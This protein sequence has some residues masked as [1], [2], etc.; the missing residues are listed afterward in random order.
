MGI[1]GRWSRAARAI[2]ERLPILSQMQNGT[3]EGLLLGILLGGI[4]FLCLGGILGGLNRG[5][6]GA[7]I[8][9]ISGMLLG[10]MLGGVIGAMAGARRIPQVGTIQLSIEMDQPMGRYA[11]GDVVSG[12]VS[13]TP[14]NTLRVNGGQ[15]YFMCR[16]FYAHDQ[17]NEN[18]MDAPE[19]VRHSREYLVR[20]AEFLPAS[21]LRRGGIVRCPFSF[22]IPEGTPPTHHGYIC[23]VRWSLHAMVEAPDLQPSKAQREVFVQAIPPVIPTPSGG[24][25]SS[26]PTQSCQLILVLPRAVYAEGEVVN[27][28]VNITALEDLAIDEVRAMLLR[29]ENTPSGDNHIVYMDSRDPVSGLYRGEREFGGQGTTYVWLEAETSLSSALH[30]KPTQS[31]SFPFA[32]AIPTHWRP[33]F[34]TKDGKVTWK[35]GVIV[36]RPQYGD[37]RVFHEIIVHTGVPQAETTP[38][39]A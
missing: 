36:S 9:A 10:T 16:G 29:I 26:V 1:P 38:N 21:T 8:G 20:Q 11:P 15:I 14:E 39:T 19:F 33:T 18:G 25:Q 6:E 24:Y 2:A 31:L 32:L 22:N 34:S 30:I 7:L 5:A 17:V 3:S 23:A 4:A 37:V 12:H 13:V 27:A 35:V 28:R